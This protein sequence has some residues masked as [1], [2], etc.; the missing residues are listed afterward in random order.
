MPLKMLLDKE[1]FMLK[2]G[3][4][5]TP[6]PD[7]LTHK[8]T[9]SER[10]QKDRQQGYRLIPK[11]QQRGTGRRT[12]VKLRTTEA[13]NVKFIFNYLICFLKAL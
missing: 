13:V 6:N 4:L 2:P 9:T 10:R 12:R 8:N 7:I 3:F 1:L 5:F 11:H